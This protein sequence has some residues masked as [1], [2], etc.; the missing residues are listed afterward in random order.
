MKAKTKRVV[1]FSGDR[2]TY[3]LPTNPEDFLAYWQHKVDLIPAE[4]MSSAQIEVEATLSYDDPYI[5]TCIFY[6]RPLTEQEVAKLSQ[7]EKIQKNAATQKELRLLAE[8][9]AK[10]EGS[11]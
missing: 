1:V 3:D 7:Q 2:A 4:Y 8:L 11:V 9:K 5:E 10:Y 6:Y